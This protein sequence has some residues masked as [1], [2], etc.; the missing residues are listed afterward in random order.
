[1]GVLL[2]IGGKCSCFRANPAHF[3]G[4]LPSPSPGLVNA[5]KVRRNSLQSSNVAF[6]LGPIQRLYKWSGF[7]CQG[8][9]VRD[10]NLCSLT[11]PKNLLLHKKKVGI[12]NNVEHSEQ[13]FCAECSTRCPSPQYFRSKIQRNYQGPRSCWATVQLVRL[14]LSGP[15]VPMR[16]RA[17]TFATSH[18]GY[19]RH[20]RRAPTWIA[21][22]KPLKKCLHSINPH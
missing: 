15:A 17:C 20:R 2:R 1:M 11:F 4:H 19:A 10:E 18:Q 12:G 5:L 8:F 14:P 22:I 6:T 21:N 9:D 16:L 3:L 13:T 7:W